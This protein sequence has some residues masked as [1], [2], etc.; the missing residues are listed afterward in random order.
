MKLL[1]QV[2]VPAMERKGIGKE[3]DYEFLKILNVK[4]KREI[5]Y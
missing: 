4:F 2:V 5:D 3:N 1:I